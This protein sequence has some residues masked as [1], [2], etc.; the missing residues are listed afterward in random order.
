M[1]GWKGGENALVFGLLLL[2]AFDTAALDSVEVTAALETEGS[3]E[4]LDLGPGERVGQKYRNY[5]SKNLRLGVG[6]GLGV[7]LGLDLTAN[8]VL[9]DIVLLGQVEES[10]NLGGTLGTKTLGEDDIGQSG[11]VLLALLDDNEGEDGDIGGDDAATDGLALALTGAAGAVARVA[12]GEEKAD[13]VGNEDTLLHGE[14][15]LVVSTGDTEDVALPL[16]A[17]RVARDFL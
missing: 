8:D 2:L 3:N 5:Q 11:D 6:L 10:A 12:V 15:L 1:R 17:Q 13:T 14:T 7:L 9:A 16:V 4:T